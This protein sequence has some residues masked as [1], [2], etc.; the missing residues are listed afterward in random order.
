MN[1]YMLN[2]CYMLNK[3]ELKIKYAFKHK[4]N[5]LVQFMKC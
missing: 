1:F 4:L 2:N 3:S 5:A